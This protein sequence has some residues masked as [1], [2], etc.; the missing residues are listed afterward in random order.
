MPEERGPSVWRRVP[1]WVPVTGA[2]LVLAV[3]LVS[4]GVVG[5]LWRSASSSGEEESA[6][7]PAE[8]RPVRRMAPVRRAA[9]PVPATVATPAPA[10]SAFAIQAASFRTERKARAALAELQRATGLAGTVVTAAS[11]QGNWY[12]VVM[13]GF[14]TQEEA[15]AKSADLLARHVVP[16]DRIVVR[17]G[18]AA[19]AGAP[20]P[21]P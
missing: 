4:S 12:R 19:A 3:L 16:S 11:A 21:T 17:A 5:R 6:T 7:V 2:L 18:A 9:P 14:A 10:G 1:L 15:T 8:V 13:G 20:A